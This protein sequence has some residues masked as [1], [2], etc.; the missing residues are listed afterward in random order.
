MR[1]IPGAGLGELAARVAVH[2]PSASLDDSPSALR[3]VPAGCLDLQGCN[4]LVAVWRSSVAVDKESLG[5]CEMFLSAAKAAERERWR[6]VS[7]DQKTCDAGL[8]FSGC[9]LPGNPRRYPH[10]HEVK[11]EVEVGGHTPNKAEV[12]FRYEDQIAEVKS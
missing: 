4:R 6:F 9:A 10:A 5:R 1:R 11:V 8:R 2:K 7:A 3:T 12:A